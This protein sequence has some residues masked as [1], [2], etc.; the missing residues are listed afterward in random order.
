MQVASPE[1]LERRIVAGLADAQEAYEDFV[2]MEGWT[3][4][5]F[6][7]FASWWS[8]V[9]VPVMRSLSMR[10]TREIAAKVIERVREEERDLPSTQRRTQAEIGRLVGVGEATV[11]R[12]AGTR[13]TR[14][15]HDARDD[16]VPEPTTP[17]P[18]PEDPLPPEIAEQV[19]RR[20]AEMQRYAQLDAE[21]DAATAGSVARFRANFSKAVQQAGGIWHFDPDRIADVYAQDFDRSVENAF[22]FEMER[23]IDRVR[24]ARRRSTSG[25]RV[26]DGG[27]A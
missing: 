15:S 7:S 21:L 4:R 27:V 1:E 16:L 23:F 18:P 13:S 26:I 8:G 12:L 14:A 24:E 22:L 6:D 9:V 11:G 25:L 10:P 3:Q 19:E 2:S 20:I 5:G 17:G